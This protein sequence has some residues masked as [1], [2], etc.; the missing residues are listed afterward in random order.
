MFQG[1]IPDQI[2]LLKYHRLIISIKDGM[3]QVH[4]NNRRIDQRPPF[5]LEVR[6][7]IFLFL[8]DKCI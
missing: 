3:I 4:L 1:F 2:K 7:L 8:A 6:I 5:R